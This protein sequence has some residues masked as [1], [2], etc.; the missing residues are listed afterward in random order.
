ML[1]LLRK[2]GESI[3]VDD[4]TVITV[5]AVKGGKVTL[6]IVS[7]LGVVRGELRE[8]SSTSTEEKG[9]SAA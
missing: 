5:T 1:V 6:G 9:S 3:V 2:V 8:E 4:S 7:N